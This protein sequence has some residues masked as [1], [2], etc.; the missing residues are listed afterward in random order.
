MIDQALLTSI[1][2]ERLLQGKSISDREPWAAECLGQVDD[3]LRRVCDEISESTGA[4]SKVEW[5]HYGSGYA[6]FV[7][8]WF[9]KDTPDF[10]VREPMRHGHE[11]T[12]LVVLLSR[13]SPFVVF[14][15]GERRW[16]GHGAS[17]Y[18]PALEAVDQLETPAV[19]TLALQVELV[20]QRHGLV[21]AKKSRLDSALDPGLRVPTILTDGPFTQFDALFYWED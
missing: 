14:M 7:D 16:H 6:S 19:A 8:A 9:Y 11:H 1:E 5:D 17:S 20:L 13:L 12:G 10:D 18:L 3:Y 15:E 2:V 4:A 21:R